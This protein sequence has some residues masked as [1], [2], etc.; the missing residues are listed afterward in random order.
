M[1]AL[2][3]GAELLWAAMPRKVAHGAQ[4]IRADLPALGVR[5]GALTVLRAR[6]AT[7]GF[8]LFQS[9]EESRK[10][11]A[12]SRTAQPAGFLT[13]AIRGVR[14]PALSLDYWRGVDLPASMR[15]EA[16]MHHWPVAAPGAYPHVMR[17]DA[18]GPRP[19]RE[20][21]ALTLATLARSLARFFTRHPHLLERDLA[22][23]LDERWLEDDVEVRFTFPF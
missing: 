7:F 23:P 22:E 4:V 11:E 10:F 6:R 3:E 5:G 18:D 17:L 9:R 12:A 20:C 15:R 14:S 8:M 19:L 16:M 2:F 1:R 21:D 13:R